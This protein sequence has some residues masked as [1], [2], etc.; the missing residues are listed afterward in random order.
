MTVLSNHQCI[1]AISG[2]TTVTA[3]LS[4]YCL[5]KN[6][7]LTILKVLDELKSMHRQSL[8]RLLVFDARHDLKA[9]ARADE[10][11]WQI[12]ELNGG[13][14]VIFV[15]DKQKPLV[16]SFFTHHHYLPRG[17]LL[18]GLDYFVGQYF[19]KKNHQERRVRERRHMNDRRAKPNNGHSGS[20]SG[21]DTHS[22]IK[23]G[24]FEVNPH[25]R[26]VYKKGRDLQ[27]TRKE[28]E[29]F[30][31]LVEERDEI[32]SVEAIL[33]QLWP[34]TPRASKSDLYQYVHTLRKK[35]EHDP[36]QPQCLLTI[37]GVGYQLHI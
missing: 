28:F 37:K 18:T 22:I 13:T 19:Y 5:A 27:L 32:C 8:F 24:E 30:M 3:Q 11:I 21:G 23:M 14:P 7:Q 1:I 29:L 26:T 12:L 36:C 33:S 9:F 16:P 15:Y 35:V 2:D 6:I 34:D 17:E 31:L 20:H 4:G 10:K 25:T